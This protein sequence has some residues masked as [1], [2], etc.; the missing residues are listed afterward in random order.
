ME[1]EIG[2]GE[3]WDVEVCSLGSIIEDLV[4][5]LKIFGQVLFDFNRSQEF[6]QQDH[7]K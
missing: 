6:S 5:N 2:V 1:V 4:R 3:C 7:S